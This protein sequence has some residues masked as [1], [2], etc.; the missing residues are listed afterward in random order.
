MCGYFSMQN[1]ETQTG[2]PVISS[3]NNKVSF[4]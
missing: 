4:V 3:I 2:N 1:D